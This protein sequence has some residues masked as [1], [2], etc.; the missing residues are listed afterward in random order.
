MVQGCG[1]QETLARHRVDETIRLR[2]LNLPFELDVGRWVVW[3]RK[4]PWT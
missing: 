4:S 2:F 1:V 3:H